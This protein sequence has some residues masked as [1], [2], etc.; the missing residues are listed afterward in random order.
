MLAVNALGVY[1][2]VCCAVSRDRVHQVLRALPH[3]VNLSI[4]LGK[5]LQYQ[6]PEQEVDHALMIPKDVRTALGRLGI[7]PDI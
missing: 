2:Y 5:A 7:D 6:V 3:I 4:A 1:L